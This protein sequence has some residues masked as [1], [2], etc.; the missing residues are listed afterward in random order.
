MV[1]LCG[2]DEFGDSSDSVFRGVCECR[3]VFETLLSDSTE[4]E[5]VSSQ[6]GH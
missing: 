2:L 4:L 3:L 5:G 1:V 6:F